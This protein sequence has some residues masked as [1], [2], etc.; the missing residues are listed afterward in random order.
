MNNSLAKI[1]LTK[2]V[3]IEDNFPENRIRNKKLMFDD[4]CGDEAPTKPKHKFKVEV[5]QCIVDQL[6]TSL[7]ERF[8]KNKSV[9]ADMQY[10]LP[11]YYN[12]VRHKLIPESVLKVKTIISFINC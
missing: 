3:F 10:L 11:K 9:I 7:I 6:Q 12:D 8:T 5:F 2:E 1:E 4:I